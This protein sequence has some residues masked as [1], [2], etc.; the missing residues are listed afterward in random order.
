[1]FIA[2]LIVKSVCDA[3]PW[4]IFALLMATMF[5]NFGLFNAINQFVTNLKQIQIKK[6]LHR[7]LKEDNDGYY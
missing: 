6:E 4:K 5:F 1:M 7:R 2:V 3:E